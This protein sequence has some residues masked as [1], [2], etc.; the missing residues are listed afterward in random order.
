MLVLD[1][2]QMLELKVKFLNIILLLNTESIIA[3]GG[4]NGEGQ[5]NGQGGVNGGASGGFTFGLGGNVGGGGNNIVT[6][7]NPFLFNFH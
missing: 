3:Q 4:A 7:L 2:V 6:M 1:L 5:G